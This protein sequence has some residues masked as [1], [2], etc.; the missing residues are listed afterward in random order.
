MHYD[1]VWGA[2]LETALFKI[3]NF[4]ALPRALNIRG[5]LNM[6]KD[7]FSYFSMKHKL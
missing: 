2:G 3:P 5:Y 1:Y 4:I 7:I 6:I